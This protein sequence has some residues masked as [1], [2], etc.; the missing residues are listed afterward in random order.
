MPCG[1]HD[2]EQRCGRS[3]QYSRNAAT[4]LLIRNKME[5]PWNGGA[6]EVQTREHLQYCGS[7]T[8]MWVPLHQSDRQTLM[9]RRWVCML[10]ARRCLEQRY[11]ESCRQ[12]QG[13]VLFVDVC[14][15][16]S[17]TT[18]IRWDC[19]DWITVN[20]DEKAAAVPRAK[21]RRKLSTVCIDSLGLSHA[22]PSR[23]AHIQGSGSGFTS[24]WDHCLL[25]TIDDSMRVL[26]V[27]YSVSTHLD[28][29]MQNHLAV[30]IIKALDLVLLQRGT[31]VC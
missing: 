22:E 18:E 13:S 27:W 31:T 11:S 2:R 15:N 5:H 4:T 30:L 16:C 21:I 28:C 6:D 3:K 9:S 17:A 25:T 14:A 12:S 29:P 1:F 26:Q 19:L 23:C 10:G 20:N 24:T 8:R 7:N